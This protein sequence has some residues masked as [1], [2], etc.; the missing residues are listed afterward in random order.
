[1]LRFTDPTGHNPID[2]LKDKAQEA[3]DW[4]VDKGKAVVSTASGIRNEIRDDTVDQ[5]TPWGNPVEAAAKALLAHRE[6][7]QLG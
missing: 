6:S 4:A 1:V 2:Y 7:A 3:L 5:S